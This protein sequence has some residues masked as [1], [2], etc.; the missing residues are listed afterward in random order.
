MKTLDV[1]AIMAAAIFAASF[2][3]PPAVFS[4][5]NSNPAVPSSLSETYD[6]WTV[7]CSKRNDKRFCA[8]Y[9]RQVQQNGQQVLAVELTAAADKSI[10]GSVILP[11]GLDLDKGV[12]FAIDD[13][14]PGKTTRFSTCLPT[15]C[16]I[17][18]SFTD[19]AITALRNGKSLKVIAYSSDSGAEIP[20]SISLKGLANGLDRIVALMK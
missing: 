7:A 13:T 18:L 8:V 3:F 5:D 1:L 4:Q 15:G 19:K 14:P 9:Q 6:D 20:F 10:K 11:F 16:L 12:A 2:A 17:A